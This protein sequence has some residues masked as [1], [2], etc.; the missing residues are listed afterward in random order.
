MPVTKTEA[1]KNFLTAATHPDLAALYNPS[2]E[3]QVSVAQDGGE[4]VQQEFKG[5]Q[6]SVYTDGLD[7]WKSFRIPLNANAEATGQR[8]PDEL[9]PG[10]PRRG[11]RPDRLGLQGGKSR[12]G[13]ASTSTRSPATPRATAAS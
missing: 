11:D 13:S 10:R 12:S 4:K 5:R 3:V 2:M 1:I 7:R 8:R 9:R 6:Y